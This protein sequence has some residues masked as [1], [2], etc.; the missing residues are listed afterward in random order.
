MRRT[1]TT[2]TVGKVVCVHGYIYVKVVVIRE[3]GQEPTGNIKLVLSE[4]L[5]VSLTSAGHVELLRLLHEADIELKLELEAK[6]DI[7]E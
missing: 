6:D 5:S 4:V 3:D 1:E 2:I 7:Q